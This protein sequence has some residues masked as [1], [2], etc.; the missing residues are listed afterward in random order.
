[1]LSS[2][3]AEGAELISPPVLCLHSELAFPSSSFPPESWHIWAIILF[4]LKEM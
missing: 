3:Q 1:M 2:G 4:I